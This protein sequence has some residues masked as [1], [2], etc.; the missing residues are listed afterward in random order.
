M[1]VTSTFPLLRQKLLPELQKYFGHYLKW[2]EWK[3]AE[4]VFESFEQID[5]AP[6]YR[7]IVGSATSPE[8]LESAT[9]KAAWLDECEDGL[10]FLFLLGF[11]V[12]RWGW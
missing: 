2:G 9:A 4:R 5:G 12:G 7:I 3:A 11:I 8:S 6:A 1:V 10:A